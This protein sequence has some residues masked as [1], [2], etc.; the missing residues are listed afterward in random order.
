MADPGIRNE[1][2]PRIVIAIDGPAGSGKSTLA[3]ILARR[4]GYINIESGAMYRALALKALEAGVSLIMVATWPHWR[5]VHTSSC[6]RKQRAT[7]CC[8]KGGT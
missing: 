4:Y 7:G 6:G 8:S 3:A 1:V 5:G 2:S